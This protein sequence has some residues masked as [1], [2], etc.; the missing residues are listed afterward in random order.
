[1]VSEEQLENL[2]LN[3]R[4]FANLAILAPGTS[5]AYNSD[6]TKPGQLTVALN[7]GIGR[8]VNY[9]IDG[10]DNTDD[11]IGGALQNFN[12]ESVA[13]FNIQT[14]Q[15]K[16]EYGRSTGGVLTVVTKTG[17]NDFDGSAWGF[18]RD[19]SLATQT[20]SEKLAGVDKQPYERQQYGIAARRPDRPR[21]RPL[22]RHL[23]EA[24][25]ARRATPSITG[26][27][28]PQLRR[29]VGHHCPS[30]T[31]WAPPRRPWTS[32]PS[33]T[34]RSATASRRTATSTAPARWPRPNALGTVS[35]EYNSI[36]AG[37]TLQIGADTLNE[38]VFQYTNVR[39]PDQRRLRRPDDLL[40]V[41]RRTSG[42]NLNTPQATNQTKYQYKD[43]FSFSR[44]L[45]GPDA[46]VQGRRQLRPRARARR[47]LLDRPAR[48]VY[49]L[50]EDRPGSPVT[51]ITVFGGFFGMDD[52]GRPVQRLS[53]RTTSS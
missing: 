48:P 17:T 14:Q 12:L 6:P 43:D 13:E 16:A 7:G 38:F 23:R 51:D 45:G 24:P 44:S 37:H 9:I 33:S 30:R 27:V 35:N 3:G 1:M 50:A 49:A 19:D 11:T 42:Q 8:N 22:L 34:C 26:G 4:Q 21:P 25:S 15:Y 41:R 20:E 18:F 40:P 32:R 29:P 52:A 28:L 47:R 2:P 31:S 39:E 10:G 5:L 46:P 36:L 53:S